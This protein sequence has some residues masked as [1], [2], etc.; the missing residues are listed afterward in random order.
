MG[1]KLR[2]PERQV[3]DPEQMLGLP[4]QRDVRHRTLLVA[5]T[6]LG[7]A[8]AVAHPSSSAAA[9][10]TESEHTITGVPGPNP[11]PPSTRNCTGSGG[12]CL[13]KAT[14]FLPNPMPPGGK[15]PAVIM[16][17]GYGEHRL[18]N[19]V[20]KAAELFSSQGYVVLTYDTRGF[21]QS[22]G[23]VMLG[24]PDH[25]LKDGRL[26][27]DFLA[28][29]PE[30]LLDGPG[31]P[32]VA[33][34]GQS[35]GAAL[36]LLIAAVDSRP[37]VLVARMAWNDLVYSL[38]P[39]G[40]I[41]IEWLTLLSLGGEIDSGGALSPDLVQRIAEMTASNDLTAA[42]RDELR[43]RSPATYGGRIRIPTFLLQGER[44]TLF[45]LVEPSRNLSM[46]SATGPATKLLW[47]WGGHGGYTDYANGDRAWVTEDPIESRQLRWLDRH[48]KNDPSIDTGPPFE[49]IDEKG[50]FRSASK[51]P[52][53]ATVSLEL[54]K[55]GLPLTKPPG[56][57]CPP[58]GAPSC[59]YTE[60]SNFSAPGRQA[61]GRAPSDPPGTFVALDTAPLEGSLP[62]LGNPR[63]SFKVTTATGQPVSLFWKF[64]DVAPDGSAELI[65]RLVSPIRATS[66]R[67]N[68]MDLAGFSYTFVKGNRLRLMVASTD[69]AYYGTEVADE[70][71]FAG[72]VLLSLPVAT[73]DVTTPKPGR[74]GNLGA[75]GGR[76]VTRLGLALLV[77]ALVVAAAWG[78]RER[79][80]RPS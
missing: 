77:F 27:I 71:T 2:N 66:G 51:V 28:S 1:G 11:P 44:D 34:Y 49:Y 32:R 5:A 29:R 72:P 16:S 53:M 33:M 61:A 70:V 68:T 75:T 63:I 10:F 31:D 20:R 62:V 36:S 37:D 58:S 18:T 65:N 74:P 3:K 25:E 19:N 35:Y 45:N 4:R 69:A 40:I 80:R 9:G 38:I 54:G 78:L 17:P 39:N 15:A 79:R 76:D 56:R 30:V 43:K 41:K 57:A 73:A 22:Q 42:T 46:I 48:L 50:A 67:D 24:S 13:L 12:G 47:F 64:F 60:A 59:S 26:L 21:G 6:G 7:L 52:P 14:L 8:V 23:Y 55:G